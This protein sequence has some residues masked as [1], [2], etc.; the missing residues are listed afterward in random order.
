MTVQE[1]QNLKDYIDELKRSSD[2]ASWIISN[3]KERLNEQLGTDN[4]K[5]VKQ[6]L[7]DMKTRLIKQEKEYRG[8]VA[9]FRSKWGDL[10]DNS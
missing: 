6:I 4:P 7:Q 3:A 8:L 10:I 1:L 2:K 9:E 5:R